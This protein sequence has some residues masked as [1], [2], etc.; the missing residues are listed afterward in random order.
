[1]YA[2]IAETVPGY[3][4]RGWNGILG[5]AGTPKS[6]IDRLHKEIVLI[7]QSPEFLKQLATEGA[8]PIGNSPPEFAAIIKADIEKWAK[9]VKV[10]GAKVD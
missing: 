4:S 1:M 5:P 2:P 9:V 8:I 6:I 10:S 3:E 7:V